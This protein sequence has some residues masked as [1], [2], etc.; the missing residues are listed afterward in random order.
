MAPH[1]TAGV[2]QGVLQRETSKVSLFS[3]KG[4]KAPPYFPC[5]SSWDSFSFEKQKRHMM[6]YFWLDYW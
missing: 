2:L 3:M 1:Q 5:V 4:P 6:V